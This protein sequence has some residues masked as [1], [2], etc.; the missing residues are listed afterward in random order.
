MITD[1]YLVYTDGA[2]KNQWG[3]WAYVIIKNNKLICEAASRCRHTDSL[4]MEIQAV[5]EALKFLKIQNNLIIRT[6]C[7]ILIKNIKLIDQWKSDGWRKPNSAP[8]PNVDLYQELHLLIKNKNIQWEWVRAHSQ[9]PYNERCDE[10]CRE[11]RGI[12]GTP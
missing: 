5:L 3:S 9:N 12:E 8:I 2:H 10:L 4:R 7:Q 11:A 6:D 1:Q